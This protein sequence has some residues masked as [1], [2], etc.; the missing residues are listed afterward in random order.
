MINTVNV[1]CVY[2]FYSD[3]ISANKIGLDIVIKIMT[4]K[5]DLNLFSVKHKTIFFK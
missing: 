4:M 1:F 2:F 5:N 3:F